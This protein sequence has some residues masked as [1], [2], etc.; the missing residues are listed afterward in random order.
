MTRS[1][2]SS[3]IPSTIFRSLYKLLLS[4]FHLRRQG[5][6]SRIKPPI[7]LNIFLSNVHNFCSVTCV[8]VQVTLPYHSN[9]LI[10][11]LL[12]VFYH[13]DGFV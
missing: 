6:L 13:F 11:V 4:L 10:M 5:P 8:R 12:I 7:L 1:S 2:Q 3:L 9:G